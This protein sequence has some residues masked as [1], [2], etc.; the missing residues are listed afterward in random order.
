MALRKIRGV[1]KAR[2]REMKEGKISDE[3]IFSRF[4]KYG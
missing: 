3:A 4:N 1:I 2:V